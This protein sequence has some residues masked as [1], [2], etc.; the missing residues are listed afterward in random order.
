MMTT[1]SLD[2][3]L[4]VM[5]MRAHPTSNFTY[6]DRAGNIV[7]YYNA[8]L[9]LLPHPVTGDTA[10]VAA[11]SADIWSELVPWRRCRSTSTP[12]GG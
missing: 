9:P 5:R 3:W 6:A 2:E 1:R 11:T 7:H 8:R 12:P 10:A 4:G